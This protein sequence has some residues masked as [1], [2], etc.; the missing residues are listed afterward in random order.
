MP[1]VLLIVIIGV[2]LTN[3]FFISFFV[4]LLCKK[5]VQIYHLFK[6]KSEYS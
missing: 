2:Y 5:Y 4:G 1:S 3:V 6:N